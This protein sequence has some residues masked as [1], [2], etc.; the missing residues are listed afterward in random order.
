LGVNLASAGHGRELGEDIPDEELRAMLDEFDLDGDGESTLPG[1]IF[2][3][4]GWCPLPSTA[5]P[6][7]WL[8][9]GRCAVG[10]A[11]PVNQDEFLAI[12][13]ADF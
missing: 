1:D 6:M 3:E 12:M 4:G 11:P 8:N 5:L 9:V 10:S 7:T 13:T 2:F